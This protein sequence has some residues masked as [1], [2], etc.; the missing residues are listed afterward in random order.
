MSHALELADD[1][2]M[3]ALFACLLLVGM[4][5]VASDHISKALDLSWE[6]LGHH[7]GGLS[8]HFGGLELYVGVLG[9]IVSAGG[10]PRRVPFRAPTRPLYTF[11]SQGSPQTRQQKCELELLS[12]GEPM[13]NSETRAQAQMA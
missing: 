8:S 11:T 9:F 10:L 6:A 3:L 12:I 13:E 7:F 1:G 4:V 2:C 5:G